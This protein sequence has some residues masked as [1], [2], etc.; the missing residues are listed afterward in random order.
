VI[1]KIKSYKHLNKREI[2]THSQTISGWVGLCPIDPDNARIEVSG[3]ENYSQLF[4]LRT[5]PSYVN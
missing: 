4:E 2:G 3:I 1:T 5:K